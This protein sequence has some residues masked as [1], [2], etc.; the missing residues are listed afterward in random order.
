MGDC[1]VA[2][3]GLPTPRRDHAVLMARFARDCLYKT[4]ELVKRLETT[5]GPET[6]DLCMRVG[7]HSGPVTAGVLRGQKARF[8]LFGDTINTTARIE[9][10]G[11]RNKIH[12]SEETATLLQKAGKGNWVIAREDKVYAKGK[13]EVRTFWYLTRCSPSENLVCLHTSLRLPHLRVATN[14]LVGY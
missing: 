1:Y 12:L 6:G 9:S 4:N 14:V 11:T 8:Q 2:V 13:G 3:A 10:N 7:L 5:L